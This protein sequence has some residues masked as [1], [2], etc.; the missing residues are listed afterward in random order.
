M[1][2]SFGRNSFS[3]CLPSFFVLAVAAAAVFPFSA[4][5]QTEAMMLTPY[6]DVTINK[7]TGA[8]SGDATFPFHFHNAFDQLD[9]D[10]QTAS[11]AGSHTVYS[12]VGNRELVNISETVPAG[13]QE[14]TISCSSNNP[15][16]AFSYAT[17]TV[18]ITAYPYS[19][20]TCTF[21]SARAAPPPAKNPVII[22]PGIMG[23][24][25]YKDY[26][27]KG[28]I[29]P[30]V[31][32]MA[33][34]L[35]DGYLDD[36]AL[37]I[38]GTENP[39]KP[40]AL[41][42]IVRSVTG[43][44]LGIGQTSHI[45]D[46]L[47]SELEA[48]GYS[49]GETLFVFPYDWRKGSAENAGL[50]KNK[51]DAITASSTTGK[52]DIIAHSM[53][54]LVTKEYIA[55]NG[56]D[57]IGRAIF[58]GVPELGAPLAFKAL[59]Y[60]DDMGVN[61]LFHT[62]SV[63]NSNRVKSITQNMPSVF[64]LLPSQKYV[65]TLGYS[66]VRDLVTP[67]PDQSC[68]ASNLSYADTK[69]FMTNQG[70]NPAMF[71][72][73]DNLHKNTDNLDLSAIKTYDI[74]GYAKPTVGM[75]TAKKKKVRTLFGTRIADDFTLNYVSGD[76]TVPL[77][78]AKNGTGK[79]YYVQNLAHSDL[80]STDDVK[81]RVIAILQGEGEDNDMVVTASGATTTPAAN[82]VTKL[83]G[84]VVSTHATT[85]VN[86]YDN[87]GN[88]TGPKPDGTI[89][90]GIPNVPYDRIDGNTFIF[91]PYP[92]GNGGGG[93]GSGG[94]SAPT[95]RVVTTA[96]DPDMLAYDF[97]IAE[98]NE[99]GTTTA[100]YYWSDVP[101]S[102][103]NTSVETVINL[104]SSTLA[105]ETPPVEE[106]PAATNSPYIIAI[107]E[108][109]D[110][111]FENENIPPVA[112][113]DETAAADSIPPVTVTTI[114]TTSPSTDSGQATTTVN[115]IASDDNAGVLKTEYSLD[116][117]STWTPYTEPIVIMETSATTTVEYFSTDRAGNAEEI[118]TIVVLPMSII[119]IPQEN[120]EEDTVGVDDTTDQLPPPPPV[121]GGGGNGPPVGITS[122][123]NPN[124]PFPFPIISTVSVSL[125]PA[126]PPAILPATNQSVGIG[127]TS[128]PNPPIVV[129]NQTQE[130][131]QVK[132]EPEITTSFLSRAES[133]ELNGSNPP[134]VSMSNP[135]TAAVASSGQ[136]LPKIVWPFVI[137]GGISVLSFTGIKLFCKLK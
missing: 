79:K 49:E 121:S 57:A 72:F 120:S 59:M 53:G 10:I 94:S 37:Q 6:F 128:A 81:T 52:V 136:S 58:I 25:L 35:S 125:P 61:T 89:E 39:E 93:G 135:Q 113:L 47:I 46:G 9:F 14:S 18:F 64:E 78:S 85:T 8:G 119:L 105:S 68:S 130:L 103:Q 86:I 100:E 62:I 27:D 56:G 34:S 19:E 5:R 134:V 111:A 71:S 137:I 88:H 60:G 104:A 28:E 24:Y 2:L 30:A 83:P 99:N 84:V 117:G 63:L 70:R 114:A 77:A 133:R 40:M 131:A 17:S 129:T 43:H 74:I 127:E 36:L 31:D 12:A 132:T 87:Q 66:Y 106:L 38:D 11:S 124:P 7:T 101:I 23:S 123:G 90:Y 115:L 54:G 44:L 109:G 4:P 50:L 21:T 95:Y 1:R 51:I 92:Q 67:S 82:L 80:P 45:F 107:D 73:A 69:Q 76:N 15:R 29:W 110:G 97:H 3:G 98:Q 75:I 102:N 32:T 26:D 16:N 122:A 65:D 112:T 55:E 126:E 116:G 108:N 33:W 91:L 20:V 48:D 22:V 96:E 118:R 13:W 42:G 41:G